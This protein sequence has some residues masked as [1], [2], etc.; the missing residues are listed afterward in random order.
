MFRVASTIRNL[1]ETMKNCRNL[2]RFH[3]FKE[4]GYINGKW[5]T[6]KSA[7]CFNVF[8]PAN[9]DVIATLPDMN[10]EDAQDAIDAAANAF[11]TW[12]FVTPKQR[13]ELLRKWFNLL[14]E[15]KNDI[16]EIMTAESG[17]PLH[18]AKVE[19][20]YGNSFIEWFS[21]EARRIHGE[22]LTSPSADKN[23]FYIMEPIGVAALIT[24][25]NFP[26]AMITRKAGA[27]LAAGCTCVVKPSADTPLT[28]LALA[29]LA[30]DA[31]IPAGVFNVLS[32]EHKHSPS[33]GKLLCESPLIAGI[34]FTGSTTIGKLLYSQ[35]AAGV[36]RIALELGGNAPFIVF[37]SANIQ[38]AVKGAM[39][40]K[41]R[42]CGQA[43]VAANRILVQDDV[44]D[45]FINEFVKEVKALKIGPG[46]EPGVNVGPLINKGHFQKISSLVEDAICKGAQAIVGGK[47]AT[48]Y[49]EQFYEPTV[50]VDVTAD[51]KVY[52][53]EVFGPVA[54]IVRFSTEAEGLNIA[55]GT[56]SG[57]AAYF[58]SQ[59]MSQVL[60][61][62]RLIEAG[63]IGIN[64]G[65]ISTAEAP[66]GGVKQ[67]GIGR[68]GSRHGLQEYTNI[69]YIC[70]GASNV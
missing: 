39:I 29:Q 70:L 4:N 48:S 49:G 42:N 24:P 44:Y 41:F 61:V 20:T 36:K 8:N 66:F 45:T 22:I 57:L 3:V 50:L 38:E 59:D 32:S 67:S 54:T 46:T 10:V 15:N 26:H 11:K 18:D 64:E 55:N 68:E 30:A 17:K 13:S 63:M 7:E 21:E 34:S 52:N 60:R 47:P 1:S 65:L 35:C 28:A 5:V 12:R 31:G 53:E 40:A 33:I 2:S 23:I 69:K 43:C 51:M 9:G 16:A 56:E 19:V 6:S 62:G 58:Y 37:N 27:A 14:E 25:W